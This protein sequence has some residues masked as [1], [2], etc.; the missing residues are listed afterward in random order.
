MRV[1][2]DRNSA[3]RGAVVGPPVP[4]HREAGRASGRR[5]GVTGA[6]STAAS[7]RGR[8]SVS[9]LRMGARCDGAR[10]IEVP[11]TPNAE[12]ASAHRTTAA[13][14][15][16]TTGRGLTITRFMLRTFIN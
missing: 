15:P 4:R 14:V 2:W 7:V 3:P 12:P 5:G 9:Q 16:A 10:G 13:S 8:S 1:M 11:A 6:F